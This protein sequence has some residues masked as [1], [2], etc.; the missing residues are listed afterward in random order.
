MK[1]RNKGKGIKKPA[2][3]SMPMGRGLVTPY[4]SLF[5][6]KKKNLSRRKENL[7]QYKMNG[8]YK[9]DVACVYGYDSKGHRVMIYKGYF[10]YRQNTVTLYPFTRLAPTSDPIAKVTIPI[11]KLGREGVR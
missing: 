7:M 6:H 2:S 4:L 10:N 3:F 5:Y 9:N 8:Y 1:K 11:T